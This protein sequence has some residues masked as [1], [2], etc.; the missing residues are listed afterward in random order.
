[1]I[2]STALSVPPVKVCNHL[3]PYLF[4]PNSFPFLLIASFKYNSSDFSTWS[5]YLYPR[6]SPA[7]MVFCNSFLAF[8]N[9]GLLT[10]DVSSVWLADEF[11][12]CFNFIP[13]WHWFLFY[14]FIYFLMSKVWII[15]PKT[16]HLTLFNAVLFF[17]D[18]CHVC[19]T[20]CFD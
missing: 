20:A 14:L 17:W 8:P 19:Y 1:M 7:G 15:W 6:L 5:L 18:V 2:I 10:F 16:F 13:T 11:Q 3:W 12:H 9:V 4:L